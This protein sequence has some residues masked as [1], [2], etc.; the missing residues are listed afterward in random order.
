MLL[1]NV[2][3][4]PDMPCL[5]TNPS[6]VEHTSRRVFVR[7]EH[8]LH[9]LQAVSCTIY[10]EHLRSG[11]RAFRATSDDALAAWPSQG[12]SRPSSSTAATMREPREQ[13]HIRTS[14]SG[15]TIP[16]G[17][18][19]KHQRSTLS[20]LRRLLHC[21]LSRGRPRLNPCLCFSRSSPPPPQVCS[22]YARQDTVAAIR[23]SFRVP[24][25]SLKRSVIGWFDLRVGNNATLVK[26][27]G[28]MDVYV[29]PGHAT[30]RSKITPFLSIILFF[31]GIV[32]DMTDWPD[33]GLCLA[34]IQVDRGECLYGD[35]VAEA[36]ALPVSADAKGLAELGHRVQ[37]NT[38][39]RQ[40]RASRVRML[41][42][43]VD[44]LAKIEEWL[45]HRCVD[46]RGD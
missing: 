41:L 23:S 34:M 17:L 14:T 21:G 11:H 13:L 33:L 6:F 29:I 39:L 35:L 5:V 36:F 24:R 10:P 8:T 25:H 27:F 4:R 28:H 18:T 22:G 46:V 15:S 3:G 20:Y 38:Y 26:C 12:V 16:H 45:V 31:I 42:N 9:I 19:C 37:D 43:L 2:D 1:H 7:H 32:A 30:G 40:D 44:Y